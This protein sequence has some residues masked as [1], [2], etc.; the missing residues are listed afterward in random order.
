MAYSTS[1]RTYTFYSHK[2]SHL[3]CS[4]GSKLGKNEGVREEKEWVERKGEREGGREGLRDEEERERER[5]RV[6]E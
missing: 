3:V 4:G 5:E 2:L 1:D 6:S